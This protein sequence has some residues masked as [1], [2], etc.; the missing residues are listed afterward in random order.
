[1]TDPRL[2]V[3]PSDLADGPI[4]NNGD[5]TLRFTLPRRFG[6][7]FHWLREVARGAIEGD[8]GLRVDAD[9]GVALD[10]A[11]AGVF[12]QVVSL[13]AEHGRLGERLAAA[14]VARGGLD[15]SAV[16]GRA[17]AA[18]V[19][20][21]ARLEGG[22]RLGGGTGRVLVAGLVAG[23]GVGG[24]REDDGD[25]EQPN[26]VPHGDLQSNGWI[27]SARRARV[28]GHGGRPEGSGGRR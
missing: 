2:V 20:R 4:V 9:A 6:F 24:E 3:R 7:D 23:E 5:W 27:L 22:R 1:M 8:L 12:R 26:D 21:V 16:A 14:A 15:G 19:D 13:D 17:A 28:A 10:M 18:D 11:I 25:G